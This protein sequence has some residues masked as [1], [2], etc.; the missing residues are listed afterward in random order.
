MKSGI[1]QD[2][3]HSFQTATVIPITTQDFRCPSN[4]SKD[5]MTHEHIL[6]TRNPL[7]VTAVLCIDMNEKSRKTTAAREPPPS[8]PISIDYDIGI[9]LMLHKTILTDKVL[10]I[11]VASNCSLVSHSRSID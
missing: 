9:L 2:S 11:A 7:A 4:G 3:E 8:F 5:H 10:P 6:Y 1:E